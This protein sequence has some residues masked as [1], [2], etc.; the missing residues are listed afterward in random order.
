MKKIN[1]IIE[2]YKEY[3]QLY[4]VLKQF[5][6]KNE[7][8]SEE[9]FKII[10][11]IKKIILSY[12][13]HV[14]K[15]KTYMSNEIQDTLLINI[16]RLCDLSKKVKDKNGKIKIYPVKESVENKKIIYK[17]IVK[18]MIDYQI[19]NNISIEETFNV[20]AIKIEERLNELQRFLMQSDIELYYGS[21]YY[22][23]EKSIFIISCANY[24]SETALDLEK[25]ENIMLHYK[26]KYIDYR[27]EFEKEDDFSDVNDDFYKDYDLIESYYKKLLIIEKELLPIVVEQWKNYLTSPLNNSDDYRYVMHCFSSGMV[28][29]NLM[30]KACCSLYTPTIE[31]L[32]YGNSGLIYDLDVDSIDTMCPD[33]AGSWPV[34][35]ELFIERDCPG[36]WQLTSLEHETFFYEYPFNS[37]IIMPSMFEN[38]CN[39][40]I[41]AGNFNYSEIFL[42]KNAKPIGV[43]YTNECQN[44]EEVKLYA[45]M[46]NLPL[47]MINNKKNKSK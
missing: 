31:N 23:V 47:V 30:N 1:E 25:I 21:I 37:K 16:L 8:S 19:E 28:A 45:E 41:S 44:I 9:E 29:P 40:R 6:V 3:E 5:Y 4:E 35:K 24:I 33:D 36:K 11:K 17:K 34:N 32:M 38:E 18:E 39:K 26:N 12:Y 43:F 13:L 10:N 27:N 2:I 20:F 46:N 7:V 42:N 14:Y 22:M 15:F